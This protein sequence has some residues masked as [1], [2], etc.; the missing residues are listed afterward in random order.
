M[1]TVS[2]SHPG[3]HRHHSRLGVGGGL[4]GLAPLGDQPHAVLE[5]EGPAGG[6]GAVLPDRVAGDSGGLDAQPLDGVD[7]EQAEGEG[8][9]LG[10]SG[11][12]QLLERGVEQEVGDVPA[13][14][15]RGVVDDLPRR[16]VGPGTA[17]PRPLGTLAGEDEGRHSREPPGGQSGR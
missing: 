7:D 16:M 5:A 8:G 6:Q 13:G 14:G 2:A 3:N 10:V 11:L 9:E 15:L 17:H 4:H 1:S 12:G